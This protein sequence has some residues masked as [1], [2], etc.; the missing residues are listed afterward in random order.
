MPPSLKRNS[1]RQLSLMGN[2]SNQS[3]HSQVRFW[4]NYLVR[5]LLGSIVGAVMVW[6]LLWQ[7]PENY[8]RPLILT[9]AAPVDSTFLLLLGMAGF[10]YCYVASSLVLVVHS[11][12]WLTTK[13]S[14]TKSANPYIPTTKR[15]VL[16]TLLIAVVGCLVIFKV[17][18]TL[19]TSSPFPNTEVFDVV[20][21]FIGMVG[22]AWQ[23]T[24]A[25]RSHRQ[26]LEMYEFYSNL[27]TMRSKSSARNAEFVESYRHLREHGNAF[28][29]VLS[30]IFFFFYLLGALKLA[31]QPRVNIEPSFQ[32]VIGTIFLMLWVLP[33]VGAWFLGTKLEQRLAGWDS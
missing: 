11:A 13:K 21:L 7:I 30:E 3:N 31:F 33:G 4:E 20:A 15:Q 12:R 2:S 9:K 25:F 19:A 18:L 24:I 23:W 5:Y 26:P 16:E 22:M 8:H 1:G 14:A 17:S 28:F 32:M 29:I 27:A 6:I 10:A